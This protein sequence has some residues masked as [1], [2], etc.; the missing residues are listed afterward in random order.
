MLII[1][2][3]ENTYPE[4]SWL[5]LLRPHPSYEDEP[6]PKALGGHVCDNKNS[7]PAERKK[8]DSTEKSSCM[9]R[10]NLEGLLCACEAAADGG[11]GG[12]GGGDI[13]AFA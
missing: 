11:S 7:K 2:D 4:L 8:N 6:K 10:S 13:I 1:D 12:G 9:K 3:K 5:L